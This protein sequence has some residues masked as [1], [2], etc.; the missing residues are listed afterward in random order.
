MPVAAS[1]T[2][3]DALVVDRLRAGDEAAFA[4]LVDTYSASLVR[5]ART[6]VPSV[7]IAEEVVQETW[8]AVVAGI[9]RFEARSSLKTW[10][11]SILINR[12]KTRARRESR[13]IPFS[14]LEKAGDDEPAVEPT[15][16]LPPDHSQWPGHWAVPP[17]PWRLGPEGKAVDR[18]SLGVVK[19]A[20]ER[21]PP[22][23]RLVVALRDVDG[24]PATEVCAALGLSEANQR[25]LLHRGRSR[26]RAALEGYFADE[27][28]I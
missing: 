1:T 12:A 16:F 14:D 19:S 18:E 6:F 15:R 21:L 24:W 3:V 25:V 4:W 20:L 23:Q 22:G 11:F 2:S 13:T 8:L 26:L 17:E 27:R 28:D 7:A 9:Q 10:L 5:V